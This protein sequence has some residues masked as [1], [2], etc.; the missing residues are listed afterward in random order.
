MGRP[1]GS[2]WCWT[3]IDAKI[4]APGEEGTVVGFSKKVSKVCVEFK[5]RTKCFAKD[6]LITFAAWQEREA[7][8]FFFSSRNAP[9]F[10]PL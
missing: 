9:A 1:I 3:L 2:K 7:V 8:G 4:C 5:K 6:E 10:S